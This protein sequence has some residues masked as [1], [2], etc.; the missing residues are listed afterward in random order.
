MR[1]E[2]PF[3][4]GPWTVDPATGQ[5]TQ[6]DEVRRARSLVMSLLLALAN[7]AGEVVTKNDLIAAA[8]NGTAVADSALTSTIAELR[9]LLGDEPKHPRYIETLPKRGYRLIAPVTPIGPDPSD[10][11][12]PPPSPVGDASPLAIRSA[13]ADRDSNTRIANSRS[14][15]PIAQ[16]AADRAAARDLRPVLAA[17][18]A[19]TVAHAASQAAARDLAEPASAGLPGPFSAA[20]DAATAATAATHAARN[21]GAP[22][23][24]SSRP[25]AVGGIPPTSAASELAGATHAARDA[26][27]LWSRRSW[28]VAF[29]LGATFAVAVI[30]LIASMTAR[31]RAGDP[32]PSTHV[33]RFTIEL[34]G[35]LKLAPES[36]PRL[37][38]SAD[39]ARMVYVARRGDG[40]QLYTRTL[41]QFEARAVDGT[42]DAKAPFFSPDGSRIGF[43]ANGEIRSVPLSGGEPTIV[44][45]ARVALGA[46]WGSDDTIVFSGTHGLGLFQ[47]PAS[48]GAPR[49]LTTLDAT[50]GELVHRWPQIL[51]DGEHVLFTAIG[52]DRADVIIVSRLT[53]ERHVVVENAQTATFVAPHHI[54]FER[55]ARL[56]VAS[57][58][59]VRFE[60]T[61]PPRVL[62]E[63]LAVTGPGFG[64]PAYAA[65]AGGVLVYVPLDPHDL[66][67]ELVWVDRSGTAASL[68][69]PLR[70]YMHPRLS[71]DG[72][73]VL[74]WLRTRDAD[75]WLLD[76]ATRKLT[77]IVTGIAARRASLSPDGREVMF[78]GPG[79]DNPITLYTADIHGGAARRLR[80]ERNS[81]Y[82]GTWTPD[83]QTIA[84]VDLTKATG[85]DI[86]LTGDAPNAPL[87]PALH[88]VANETA[89]AFSPD[90]RWL[91]YVSDATG[92]EEVYLLPRS[93]TGTPLQVSTHGGREPVWAKHGDELFF[94][95][96]QTMW[97]TQVSGGDRPQVSDP[98]ALFT[99]DYDQRPSFHASYDVATDGRFLMIRG[100]APSTTDA[101]MAVLLRWD[102][103]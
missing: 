70:S 92:R 82:A 19:A 65:A 94:R 60:L 45:P 24:G 51:P 43:F 25:A 77:R 91:A 79:P 23:P 74:T 55:D 87:T 36:T 3:Q 10:G 53:G 34:P 14:V 48:G 38:L 100:S 40:S 5:L 93:L 89:P 35:E 75:V 72:R 41:E 66:E 12:I 20:S 27:S 96:G 69:A 21:V 78:D 63:D 99:G 29:V 62:V 42:A 98:V 97:A 1:G 90:G 7:R 61:G 47:V 84:Y 95:Q 49:P 54:L 13:V 31:K 15:S 102:R 18:D 76:I 37:A 6:G 103:P 68:N 71:P 32:V 83:G 8:W 59:P 26:A 11:T 39:G 57:I 30:V 101:R 80:P 4:L 73:Q 16:A 67:R 88:S 9:D 2:R 44:C 58:D 85:F 81:K 33:M 86:V 50:R 22:G 56:V 46:S 64:P 28:R 52:H 17:S